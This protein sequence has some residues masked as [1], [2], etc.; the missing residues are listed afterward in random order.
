MRSRSSRCPWLGRK[1]VA[2]GLR[3]GEYHIIEPGLESFNHLV[4]LLSR[5]RT[6]DGCVSDFRDAISM[7]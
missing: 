3:V 7:S 2:C 4:T 5:N 6:V 1:A